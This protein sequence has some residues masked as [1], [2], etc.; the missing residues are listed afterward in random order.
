MKFLNVIIN[1]KLYEK[2]I[3]SRYIIKITRKDIFIEITFK[4][5]KKKVNFNY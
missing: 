4:K 2:Y 5:R 1:V 3:E